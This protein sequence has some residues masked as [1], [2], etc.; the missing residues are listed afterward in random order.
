MSVLTF[1]RFAR[2]STPR[3]S[4][5]TSLRLRMTML[6]LWPTHTA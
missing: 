3:A 4:R 5:S 2:S 6:P 1:Y